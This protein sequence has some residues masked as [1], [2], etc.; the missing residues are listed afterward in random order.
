MRNGVFLGLLLLLALGTGR[1][2]ESRVTPA[3]TVSETLPKAAH[4]TLSGTATVTDGDSLEM[5]GTRIRLNAIDAPEAAQT[6][7]RPTAIWKCGEV[8]TRKLRELVGALPI[9]CEKTDTDSYGRTV[10]V[11]RSGAVDL[12]AEMVS[13]GLALA[14]RQYGDEYVD[15]EAAARSARRGLWKDDFTPPWDWRR[16]PRNARRNAKKAIAAQ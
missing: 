16:P 7:G 11:C 9:V 10:A 8:A 5:D 4:Q 1:Y 3:G 12:A 14:Y 6:C 2:C 15:E 13:A